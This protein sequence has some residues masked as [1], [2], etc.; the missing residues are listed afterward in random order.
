MHL[1]LRN[2][3]ATD[4]EHLYQFQAD[5]QANE[6]ADFPARDRNAFFE[7]WQSNILSHADITAKAIIVDNDIV[8]SVVLWQ[9]EQQWLLGYWL[10]RDYWGQGIGTNA[11]RVFLAEQTQR[12]IFAEVTQDNLGSIKVLISNG[13]IHDAQLDDGQTNKS[14][15]NERALLLF[16]LG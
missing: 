3:L 14:T 8:G 1:Q 12:P 10:G 16:R 7:H 11:L 5:P 6:M 4:L 2:V 13:F 15:D 9:S